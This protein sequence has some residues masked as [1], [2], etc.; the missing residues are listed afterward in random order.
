[1]SSDGSALVWSDQAIVA[2]A[3][4][5]ALDSRTPV[6]VRVAVPTDSE[7]T[8]DVVIAVGDGPDDLPDTDV[9]IRLPSDGVGQAVLE[10]DGIRVSVDVSGPDDLAALLDRAL[11]PR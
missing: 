5:R 3:L 4:A 7:T 10:H 9:V 6:E 2:D 1:M 8:P 11:P